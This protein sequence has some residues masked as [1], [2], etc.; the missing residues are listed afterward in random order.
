MND[1]SDNDGRRVINSRL[2]AGFDELDLFLNDGDYISAIILGKHLLVLAPKDAYLAQK[3]SQAYLAIGDISEAQFYYIRCLFFSKREDISAVSADLSTYFGL[4]FLNERRYTEAMAHFKQA[5]NTDPTHCLS[6]VRCI[7]VCLLQGRRSAALDIARQKKEVLTANVDGLTTLAVISAMN[8]MFGEARQ[9]SMNALKMNPDHS[10]A[11][12]LLSVLETETHNLSSY[13]NLQVLQGDYDEALAMLNKAIEVDPLSI[14]LI[15]QRANVHR[16]FHNPKQ[17]VTELEQLLKDLLDNGMT[18]ENMQE[19]RKDVAVHCNSYGL[20]CFE[21]KRHLKAVKIF[22]R[23]LEHCETTDL[24]I[25]R[26]ET[27]SILEYY[28][29]ATQDFLRAS[30]LLKIES[31]KMKHIAKVVKHTTP[32]FEHQARLVEQKA[33]DAVVRLA[34]SHFN[35]ACVYFNQSDFPRAYWHFSIAIAKN[36]K[37]VAFYI[38]RA[39]TAVLLRDFDKAYSDLDH[40]LKIAPKN[41]QAKRMIRQ[42]MPGATDDDAQA[43]EMMASLGIQY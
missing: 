36:P 31:N 23:G 27:L 8:S 29:D 40:V 25:N 6:V 26:G 1:L 2:A 41:N 39:R 13:A 20:Q 42:L 33:W 22:T 10:P 43:R 4:V 34:I 3:I 24:L 18:E 7:Q 5:M 37:I 19:I 35:Q 28:P 30:E 38:Y 17:A 12:K 16:L 9:L 14:D 11:L 32:E 15:K 21:K